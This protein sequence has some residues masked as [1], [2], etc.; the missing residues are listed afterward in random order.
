MLPSTNTICILIFS[1]SFV[2]N[3]KSNDINRPT[4]G[5]I[6]WDA[7]NLVHGQYDE[8]SF[9][10]HRAMSPEH[11]HYRLPFFAKVNSD[12]N[13]TINGDTQEIMD[14]EI[15]YASYAGFDYWAF[16]TYC[17][18]GPNCTTNSPYCAQY[19]QQTSTRYCPQNPAYGLY[20]YLSSRY[21]A[22]I[23]FTFVL[24][25]SSPCGD[26]FQEYYIELMMHRQFQTVLGG[27]PLLYLFQFDDQEAQLCG[28]GWEGSRRVF[29]SF[30]QKVINRGLQNPY[31]V[32]MDGDIQRCKIRAATIG[33]DAISSYGLG[34]GGT[35]QGSPFSDE[36]QRSVQWWNAA[37]QSG[38]KVVI[39][40]STGWDPRPRY[41]HPVP[42]VDQGP[43]HFLQPTAKE[44]Q[45]FLKTS[46]ELTCTNQNVTE[47]QTVIVYAWN[48]NSENGAALIPS[49]G[50]GTY[51][52]SALS[53]MLPMTC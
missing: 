39:P 27:R 53:D 38:A 31:L 35:V 6:R 23:N 4:V 17:A 52:I 14:K 48:E 41:E 49:I 22:L 30:R 37:L 32:L 24:L 26:E 51:Y 25:G 18:F 50:N 5:I 36:V 20:R 29:D 45:D 12:T 47:A 44:L 13:V 19:Y 42:W 8:I 33:F 46:L 3:G 40:L 1:I 21:I 10:S 34:G 9:Y 11:F 43:E 16:D 7:W 2:A 28:G 15:L